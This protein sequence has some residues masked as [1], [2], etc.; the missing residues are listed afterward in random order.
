MALCALVL[1]MTLSS[2]KL[3]RK[4]IYH[5]IFDLREIFFQRNHY[6]CLLAIVVTRRFIISFIVYIFTA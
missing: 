1:K 2:Q 6:K 3:K 4:K 5:I